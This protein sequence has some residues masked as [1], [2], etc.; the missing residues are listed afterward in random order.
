M[1]PSPALD[2]SL[3]PPNHTPHR[4]PAQCPGSSQHTMEDI[5]LTDGSNHPLRCLRGTGGTGSSWPQ[6]SEV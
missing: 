3:D 2:L 6:W 5:R 1:S 4:L